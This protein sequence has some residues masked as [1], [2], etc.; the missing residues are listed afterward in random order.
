MRS[1]RAGI[2]WVLL[3]AAALHLVVQ[4]IA[5]GGQ[6]WHFEAALGI[7][8]LRSS[9]SFVLAAAVVVGLANW[10]S[11][12]TWLLAGAAALAVRGVVDLIGD[13]WL[14][15]T[16]QAPAE[17]ALQPDAWFPY[18]RGIASTLAATLAPILLSVGLWRGATSR[19]PLGAVRRRMLAGIGLVGAL[20]LAAH[21]LITVVLVTGTGMPLLSGVLYG[22]ATA[23]VAGMIALAAVGL[24]S[25]GA[26]APLPGTLIAG[27]ATLVVASAAMSAWVLGA[28]PVSEMPPGLI[29]WAYVVPSAGG[30]VGMVAVVGGFASGRLVPETAR[31]PLPSPP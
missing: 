31:G 24:R 1:P 26:R 8:S 16:L 5:F 29:G 2:A 11:G 10:P 14:W 3:A 17:R 6:P 7:A 21:G 19:S 28:F 15:W 4:L 20:A 30:L 12:R 13:A 27:G 9:M 23:E 22:L 25:V 18:A